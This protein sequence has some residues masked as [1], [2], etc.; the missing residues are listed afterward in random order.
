MLVFIIIMVAIANGKHILI[1][2]KT[3]SKNI[4]KDDLIFV[5]CRGKNISYITDI[6]EHFSCN[7]AYLIKPKLYPKQKI[8]IY[9]NPPSYIIINLLGGFIN[10]ENINEEILNKALSK[11]HIIDYNKIFTINENLTIYDIEKETEWDYKIS[12]KANNKIILWKEEYYLLLNYSETKYGKRNS[13]VLFLPSS[14]KIHEVFYP[15]LFIYCNN[16]SFA[17]QECPIKETSFFNGIIKNHFVHN[18]NGLN[19]IKYND[20]KNNSRIK[21]IEREHYI[22]NQNCGSKALIKN[23]I[24]PNYRINAIKWGDRNQIFTKNTKLIIF[25]SG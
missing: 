2:Q 12:I 22:E 16:I 4:T 1:S 17:Y 21:I 19:L 7:T 25:C 8:V 5:K 9:T 3:V 10:Y 6:E 18:C 20:I 11:A 15:G 14:Q 24:I 13:E 23:N